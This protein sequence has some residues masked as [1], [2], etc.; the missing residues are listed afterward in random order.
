MS[1][2]PEA[3]EWINKAEG[4][5]HTACRELQVRE[6]PNYDAVCFHAQQCVEKY[7]KARLAGAGRGFP[8]IHDLEALLN[9]V[10]PIEPEWESFRQELQ[11][12]TDMA[13]EVRYPGADA[14]LDDAHEAVRA[15]ERLR[16][17]AR[18]AMKLS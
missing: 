6:S 14:D 17:A 1:P 10:L 9:R 8:R 3:A 15:A 16:S 13:V 11:R 5:F 4:D 12:L 18:H 7:L 2:S